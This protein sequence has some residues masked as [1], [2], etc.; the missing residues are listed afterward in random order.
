MTVRLAGNAFTVKVC[1]ACAR[2]AHVATFVLG[3]IL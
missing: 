3:R 1:P 2:F